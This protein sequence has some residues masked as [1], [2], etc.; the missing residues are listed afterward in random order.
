MARL[1][2][3]T[4][5]SLAILVVAIGAVAGG[6]LLAPGITKPYQQG[7]Q[8]Q[9]DAD[10]IDS[11]FKQA[12]QEMLDNNYSAANASWSRLLALKP[13]MPEAHV[14]QGFTLIELGQAQLACEHF[15]R[16]TEI[17]RFQVNGYYGLGVCLEALGDIR[18]ALGAMRAYTHL[19]PPDDPFLR[20]ANA[21]IWQWETDLEAAAN[22]T[23]QPAPTTQKI[24]PGNEPKTN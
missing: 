17:N 18:A 10:R 14:N 15:D 7:T 2:R 3:S 5:L 24:T 1:Q 20:K 8:V 4:R 13:D 21:A 12:V 6:W 19:A 16:A 9:P 22:G 23:Q 11:I